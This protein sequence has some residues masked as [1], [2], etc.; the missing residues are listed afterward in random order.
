MANCDFSAAGTQVDDTI[1]YATIDTENYSYWIA[2][3]C[4][5]LTT[6]TRTVSGIRIKYTGIEK[7]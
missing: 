7:N 6:G 5:N 2:L 4:M 3:L 1:N